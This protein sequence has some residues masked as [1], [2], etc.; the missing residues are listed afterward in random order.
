MNITSDLTVCVSTPGS[1]SLF[2]VSPGESVKVFIKT[3]TKFELACDR[4]IN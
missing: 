3:F 4:T 2:S 1:D